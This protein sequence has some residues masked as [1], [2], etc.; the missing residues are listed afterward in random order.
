MFF[1]SVVSA[2]ILSQGAYADGNYSVH[3]SNSPKTGWKTYYCI[4]AEA[5]LYGNNE[6]LVLNGYGT[7]E[8]SQSAGEEEPGEIYEPKSTLKPQINLAARSP[9]W[10]TAMPFDISV[11]PSP[12]EFQGSTLY[13]HRDRIEALG[14]FIGRL[15]IKNGTDVTFRCHS[16][17]R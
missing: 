3:C 16:S 14:E 12:G 11:G 10:R 1:L 9:E 13:L 7:C 5:R 15:K 2:W 8:G 17:K 4:W 6:I